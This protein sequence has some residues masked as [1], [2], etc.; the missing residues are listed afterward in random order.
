MGLISNGT[1]VFDAG[2]MA[3]GF[4]SSMVFIK[5]LTASGSANLTFHNGTSNVILDSTYKEYLFTFKNIHLASN[6][7]FNFQVNAVGASGFNETISSTSFFMRHAENGDGDQ[8]SYSAANDQAQGTGFQRIATDQ[9]TG[10]DENMGG[11]LRLFNPAS[12]TFVKHFISKLSVCTSNRL[13]Y[14]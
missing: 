12:T 5:K 4:G 6:T 3:S 2:S 1:T 10:N 8:L 13:F 14:E 7:P 9:G 11:F